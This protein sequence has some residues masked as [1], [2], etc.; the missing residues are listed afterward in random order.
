MSAWAVVRSVAVVMALVLTAS[1]AGVTP[2]DTQPAVA[3]N[4]TVSVATLHGRA[5]ELHLA[6]PASDAARG[7]LVIYASGDGG[8]F[9]T[10]VDMWRQIARDGYVAVGFSAR[11]FLKIERPRG[12]VMDPA[13]I[14]LE[15]G[16]L[17]DQSRRMLGLAPDT[18]VI[19]TGWSR[20]AS[21][22][23]LAGSEPSFE[24]GLLGIVAIG[25]AA[26]EDLLI[27]GA[28][29]ETDEGA[30]TR[31]ARR[32]PFDNYARIAMLPEPCAVIQ[33]THDNY[34][35]ADEAQRR[36]GAATPDRRFYAIE[37]TN[38]RFSHGTIAFNQALRDSLQWIAGSPL[39]KSG[40]R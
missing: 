8:W 25:L 12:S 11:A 26:D 13:Q 17:I 28:E 19:L 34:F 7:P 31:K 6:R 5:L 37:A 33:A 30:A 21:F 1:C 36:F 16:T 3:I 40:A 29:D 10:A 22:A 4:E 2:P 38:H 14:A 39:S 27:N 9:G 35:P 32:R 23:V 15:Y 20:G 18:P 24:H